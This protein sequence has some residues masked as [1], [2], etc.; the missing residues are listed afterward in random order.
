MP[1][2]NHSGPLFSGG[3]VYVCLFPPRSETCTLSVTSWCRFCSQS[4]GVVLRHIV[5]TCRMLSCAGVWQRKSQFEPLSFAFRRCLA[6]RWWLESWERDMDWFPLNQF[7][8]TNPSTTGWDINE[9]CFIHFLF[10]VWI[11]YKIYIISYIL[12]EKKKKK[13]LAAVFA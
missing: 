6:V 5:S 10:F 12:Y 3:V 11:L 4:C 9:W 7:F 8:L 2:Y 1:F 13:S